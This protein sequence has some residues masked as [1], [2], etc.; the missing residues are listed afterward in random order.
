MMRQIEQAS[1]VADGHGRGARCR[2]CRACVAELSGCFRGGTLKY[3]VRPIRR[4][5]MASSGARFSPPVTMKP[6][7]YTKPVLTVIVVALMALARESVSPKVTVQA[8]STTPQPGAAVLRFDVV[9]IRENTGG[10]AGGDGRMSLRDGFLQVNNLLLKSLITSAYGV[11]EGLIF[12]LPRWAEEAHYDIR[13]KVTDADPIVLTTMSREQRRALMVAMLEGRFQ[14]KVH[15]VTRELPVYDLIVTKGGPRIS[16]STRE[17]HAEVHKLEF[18]GTA[19]P[20]LGLSSFL[21]ELVGRSVVDKTGL[22][23][24][25]DFRLQWEPDETVA[26]HDA[27]P[28][29]FTALQEQLGLKLQPNKGPVKTLSVD[30]LERPSEN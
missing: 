20:I 13:A 14:L 22:K 11:H 8:Q 24:A 17:Q 7:L 12:G 9:S 3:L 23:G 19:V 25:Y 1:P 28:S 30:H 6:H 15:P 18:T 5:S 2:Q 4:S 26:D 29:I 21:E 10:A 27:F 16:E